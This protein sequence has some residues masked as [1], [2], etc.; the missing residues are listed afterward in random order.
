MI[1]ELKNQSGGGLSSHRRSGEGGSSGVRLKRGRLRLHMSTLFPVSKVPS[2][3]FEA[4]LNLPARIMILSIELRWD[5]DR[6][7]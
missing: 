3:G 5:H 2:R 4:K 1:L 7:F 6:Q